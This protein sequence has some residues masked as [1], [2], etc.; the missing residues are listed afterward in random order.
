MKHQASRIIL[1]GRRS[2]L[3]NNCRKLNW[4]SLQEGHKFYIVASLLEC[5]TNALKIPQRKSLKVDVTYFD[6][7]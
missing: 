1:I 5:G 4:F 3:Q 2:R 7:F 6:E